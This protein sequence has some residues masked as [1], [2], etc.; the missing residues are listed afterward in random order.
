[1]Y[2]TSVFAM[3][4]FNTQTLIILLLAGV[5][6]FGNRLPEMGRLL[7]KG[8]REFQNG[9]KGVEDEVTGSVV[10][11]DQPA[12]LTRLQLPQRITEPTSKVAELETTAA[13]APMV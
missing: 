8:I 12:E 11:Q 1:M 4:S 6:L 9:I 13:S 2:L 7:A 10:R 5:L 3:F